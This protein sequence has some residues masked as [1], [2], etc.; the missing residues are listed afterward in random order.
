MLQ[1]GNITEDDNGTIVWNK[2][3][4]GHCWETFRFPSI[5]SSSLFTKNGMFND[6]IYEN[7][8]FYENIYYCN[9]ILVFIVIEKY[10]LFLKNGEINYIHCSHHSI[11]GC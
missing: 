3:F 7:C 10:K 5:N 9:T 1:E 2:T 4:Y 11:N 6:K 8:L